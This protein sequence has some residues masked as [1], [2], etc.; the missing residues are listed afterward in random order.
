MKIFKDR[1]A[2]GKVLAQRLKDT[3]A[4][5]VLGIPRGG[6]VV[7]NE[8]AKSLKLPL[9]VIVTRK[10]G[11]PGQPELALGAID[12]DG[13]AVWEKEL[14]E[15]LRFKM[16]DLGDEVQKQ[17]KELKRREDLYRGDKGE[18]KIGDK[19]VILVDD[20]MATGATVLA[21]V[22][23]LKRRGAYVTLAIPVASRDALEKVKSEVD[24]L[25]VLDTPIPFGSVGQFYHEFESV[26]DETVVQLLT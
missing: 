2:A 23:Y 19:I 22:G 25:V 7:A 14:L 16:G 3:R 4:D 26:D 24:E 5:L 11:A 18:L 1:V 9:D 15:E 20:G 17:W 10:I 12:P 8:V 13:E 21:A 6:V